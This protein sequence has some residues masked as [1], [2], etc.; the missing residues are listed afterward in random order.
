MLIWINKCIVIIYGG[1]LE[2]CV[3]FNHSLAG[4]TAPSFVS[5]EYIFKLVCLLITATVGV[6]A[7]LIGAL[8][9]EYVHS[10]TSKKE[11]R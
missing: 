3:Y 1:Q 2:A 8:V 10:H 4:L 7:V 11:R 5:M 6:P 9:S